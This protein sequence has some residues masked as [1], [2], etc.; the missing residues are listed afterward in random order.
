MVLEAV[1][2]LSRE[3]APLIE[4]LQGDRIRILPRAGR[5]PST[6]QLGG[7]DVGSEEEEEMMR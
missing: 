1:R 3:D 2:L 7:G 5:G 4:I 6:T